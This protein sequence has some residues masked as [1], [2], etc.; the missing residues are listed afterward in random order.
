MKLLISDSDIVYLRISDN[1]PADYYF[2]K[3]C[4][5]NT[6]LDVYGN[7]KIININDGNNLS[8]AS[9]KDEYF[10]PSDI[11]ETQRC[12]LLRQVID[13]IQLKRGNLPL[14]AAAVSDGKTTFVIAAESG[15]GKSYISDAVCKIFPEYYIIGD[16]HII[17]SSKHIQGNV[18]RRIRDRYSGK[19]EY[20]DN[21]GL[22]QIHDIIFI[23]FN[24][25]ETA[26]HMAYLSKSD[27]LS[28]YS[29][30]SAFKYL[31]E[32]FLYNNKSYGVERITEIDVDNE[33]R[34]AFYDFAGMSRVLYVSGTPQYAI[35]CISDR[36]RNTS[37]RI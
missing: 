2:S 12:F 15:K 37:I 6:S 13:L 17:I 7:G 11:S 27:A 33:Y 18:K 28:Q 20:A 23:C 25:S 26:G 35:E 5:I 21:I 34:K 4:F 36:I 30:V 31:N 14:H 29:S 16:D 24:F 19:E 1:A 9:E 3:L 8:Y 22:D 32:V 10:F